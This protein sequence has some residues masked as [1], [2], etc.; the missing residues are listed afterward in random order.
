MS[1]RNGDTYYDH[2][3]LSYW[4]DQNELSIF[5]EG[6]MLTASFGYSDIKKMVMDANATEIKGE[7]EVVVVIMN[8][9]RQM[10]AYPILTKTTKYTFGC[11]TLMKIEGDFKEIIDLLK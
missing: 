5:G 10:T 7:Q 2:G 3:T 9:V 8:S 11:S 6:T 1:I 4:G